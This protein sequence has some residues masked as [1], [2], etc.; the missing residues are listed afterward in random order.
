[1]INK[2]QL[3]EILADLKE[4]C[5]GNV[6]NSIIFQ[7]ACSYQRGMMA[8]ENRTMS[9]YQ[10]PKIVEPK[11]SVSV[12]NDDKPTPKQIMALKRM[13]EY[14]EGITKKQAWARINASK[15]A[16]KEY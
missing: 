16:K 10:K 4:V 5:N 1:M 9:N 13:G 6:S 3:K 14:F 11:P 2:I 8:G 12:D 7:E 15:N